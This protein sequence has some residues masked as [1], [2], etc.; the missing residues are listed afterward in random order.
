MLIKAAELIVEVSAELLQGNVIQ[1]TSLDER[2]VSVK[3]T[4]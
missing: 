1:Q 2:S 3:T 4:V